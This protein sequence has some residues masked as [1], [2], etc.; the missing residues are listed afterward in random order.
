MKK[1]LLSIYIPTFNRVEYLEGLLENIYNEIPK[2]E[3]DLVEVVVSDNASEDDTKS[4]ASG[5]CAKYTGLGAHFKYHRNTVN[6][7]SCKNFLQCTDYVN[8]EWCWLVGDDDMVL[9]DGIRIILNTIRANSGNRNINYY[10][11]NYAYITLEERSEYLENADAQKKIGTEQYFFQNTDI[12]LLDGYSELFGLE[13]RISA[14]TGTFLGG[15][16]FRADMWQK[17][18]EHVDYTKQTCIG[19]N[20]HE[21]YRLSADY[22][23]PHLVIAAKACMNEQIGYIG[24]PCIG[25]GVGAQENASQNWRFIDTVVF[26]DLFSQYC[27]CGM[28]ETAQ[29]VFIESFGADCGKN[30][31]GILAG[32]GNARISQETAA[33]YLQKYGVSRQFSESFIEGISY[34]L[35]P[36]LKAG[37]NAFAFELLNNL[38]KPYIEQNMRIAIWGTGEM[39][40]SMAEYCEGLREH[41]MMLI[42]GSRLRWGKEMDEFPGLTVQ[43]P[44]ALK[45]HSV[46]MIFISSMKYA[47]E[48]IEQIKKLDIRADVISCRGKMTL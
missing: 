13:S 44:E 5:L 7:G 43:S 27:E 34:F 37:Y 19:M 8:G 17:M 46:D 42:D 39:A 33:Q 20:E 45:T 29:N 1:Y 30:L 18:R 23:F 47:D 21:E 9:R 10:C 40:Q 6:I 2:E 4:A 25:L 15:N 12:M 35:V 48:I 41:V 22:V 36:P 24:I 28:S 14:H 16:L 26:D 32:H 3:M 38:I 31:A 11:L